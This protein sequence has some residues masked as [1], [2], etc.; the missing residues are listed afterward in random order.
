MRRESIKDTEAY[1]EMYRK[2]N[3]TPERKAYMTEYR[4][5]RREAAIAAKA[6]AST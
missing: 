6:A 1:K 5:K 4:R 3:N 2:R